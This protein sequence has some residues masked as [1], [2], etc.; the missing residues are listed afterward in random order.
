MV[1]NERECKG[2]GTAHRIVKVVAWSCKESCTIVSLVVVR[3]VTGKFRARVP[4]L[5]TSIDVLVE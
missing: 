2:G 3:S 1:N 5:P 4:R